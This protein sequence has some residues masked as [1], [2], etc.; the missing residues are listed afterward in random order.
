MPFLLRL[1]AELDE[2]WAE[3]VERAVTGEDRR[4]RPEI[5]LIEDHLL[6]KA[7]A[8]PAILLGP[9]D[10]DPAGGIHFLLPVDALLER[11]AVGRD[12]RIRRVF[13][14]E[15]VGQ[16]GVEPGA[17]L[18]AKRGMFRGV[19]EIHGVISP[20]GPLANSGLK[21]PHRAR[22]FPQP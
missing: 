18:A 2:G 8:T 7:R 19:G 20:N 15:I 11:L 6:D 3:Q 21:I 10:A 17:E 22:A 16:V 13:D 9:R 14:L 12:A 1:G 5:L 4:M